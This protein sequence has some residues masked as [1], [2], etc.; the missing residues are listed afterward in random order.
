MEPAINVH[1]PAGTFGESAHYTEISEIDNLQHIS[2]E[3]NNSIL[4]TTNRDI[5]LLSTEQTST[6]SDNDRDSS[7][8]IDDGYEQPY[9]TLVVTDQEKDEHDYLTTKKESNYENSISF[10]NVACGHACENQDENTLSNKTNVHD[11]ITSWN[12][13]YDMNDFNETN[14]SVPQTYINPQMNKAEYVN[15][16]LNQ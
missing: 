13:N 1:T 12:L 10:Q 9:T 6:S 5:D 7:E 14:D 11:E 3:H 16:S 8:Y 4:P 2:Q 15:L